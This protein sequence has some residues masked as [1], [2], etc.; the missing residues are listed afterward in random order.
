[1]PALQ[2]KHIS[3]S[4]HHCMAVQLAACSPPSLSYCSTEGLPLVVAAHAKSILTRQPALP[5]PIDALLLP[6]TCW[7]PSAQLQVLV[8]A[9][10][11]YKQF[12]MLRSRSSC[13]CSSYAPD[14]FLL[15]VSM[16]LQELDAKKAELR[17]LQ[18]QLTTA[19]KAVKA[20]ETGGH[21]CS[22]GRFA[23]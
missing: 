23:V 17:Q 20:A 11:Q 6:A 7:S 14:M 19:H 16:S 9:G 4:S 18:E 13:C 10:R 3:R 12:N 8:H 5:P 15:L 21:C 1:M 22:S 2:R